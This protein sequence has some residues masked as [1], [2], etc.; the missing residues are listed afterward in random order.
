MTNLLRVPSFDVPVA[1]LA[2]QDRI[3]KLFCESLLFMY[4]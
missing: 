4:D 2:V 3:L 1:K